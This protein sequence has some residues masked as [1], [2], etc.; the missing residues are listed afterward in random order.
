MNQKRPKPRRGFSP[1]GRKIPSE[2]DIDSD[3][4]ENDVDYKELIKDSEKQSRVL[5]NLS[6]INHQKKVPDLKKDRW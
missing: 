5:S 4:L 1:S 3:E 2:S 6:N